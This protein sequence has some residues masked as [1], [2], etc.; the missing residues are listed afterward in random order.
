M[1]SQ[2]MPQQGQGSM[3]A[4]RIVNGVGLAFDQDP[5]LHNGNVYVRTI[6]KGGAAETE[7]SIRVG[8]CVIAVDQMP[9]QGSSLTN[10]KS[11]L[12]GELGSFVSLT[13][14]R[15]ADNETQYEVSLMRGQAQAMTLKEKQRLAALREQLA[16]QLQHA[17]VWTSAPHRST[18]SNLSTSEQNLP[19]LASHRP[20]TNLHGSVKSRGALGVHQLTLPPRSNLEKHRRPL[21]CRA[22][23]SSAKRKDP[24]LNSPVWGSP[25]SSPLQ[26]HRSFTADPERQLNN[27]PAARDWREGRGPAGCW[28]ST[29]EWTDYSQVDMMGVRFKPVRFGAGKG[30]GPPNR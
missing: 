21:L 11:I 15:D 29:G 30:A 12:R 23:K 4:S 19:G 5:Q 8:D 14:L 6:M 3:S 27:S 7:G 25:G 22:T 20:C 24:D 18:R 9:V 1:Q 2:R 28:G 16:K 26:S 13:M 10:L 17:Q